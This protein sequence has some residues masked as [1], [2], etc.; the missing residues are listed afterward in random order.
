MK[1][2]KYVM[3]L[4]YKSILLEVGSNTWSLEVI[5]EKRIGQTIVRL[6]RTVDVKED[7]VG[8]REREEFRIRVTES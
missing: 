5:R 7:K 8:L 6:Q 3:V 2:I 4:T 1:G